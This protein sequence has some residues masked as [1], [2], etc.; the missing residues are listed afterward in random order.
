MLGML[1]HA[2]KLGT[3]ETGLV[4]VVRPCPTTS[5]KR[6]LKKEKKNEEKY[7]Y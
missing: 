6:K 2:C 1:V 4:Y 3:Q 7:N 5:K